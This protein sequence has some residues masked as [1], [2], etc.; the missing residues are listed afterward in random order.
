[1][2]HG[3]A[4]AVRI[5]DEDLLPQGK[6]LAACV[7]RNKPRVIPGPGGKSLNDVLLY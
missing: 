7:R 3:G 6:G 1:M 4:G 5:Y 2:G